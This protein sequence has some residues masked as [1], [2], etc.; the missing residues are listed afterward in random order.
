MTEKRHIPKKR[1]L[2]ATRSGQG[3][4]EY[5]LTVLLVLGLFSIMNYRIMKG[6]GVLWKTLAA[7]IASACPDCTRPSQLQQ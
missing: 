5:A 1:G 3:L 4:V 2:R 6:I 7:E